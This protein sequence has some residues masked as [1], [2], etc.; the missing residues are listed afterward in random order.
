MSEKHLIA[1]ACLA[2]SK[3]KMDAIVIMFLFKAWLKRILGLDMSGWHE[4]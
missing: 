4:T 2:E 1:R 3:H